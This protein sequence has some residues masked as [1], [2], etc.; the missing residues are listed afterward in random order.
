MDLRHQIRAKGAVD[1]A[2]AR[3]ARHWPEFGGANG[4]MKM[5]F[6]VSTIA[7]MPRVPFAVIPDFQMRR[8]KGFG[9][10]L[11]NLFTLFHFLPHGPLQNL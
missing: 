7:R 4:H 10:L 2:V 3:D 6:A 1:R 9:K 11:L 8:G 5:A